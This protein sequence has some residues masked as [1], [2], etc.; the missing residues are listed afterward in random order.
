MASLPKPI[1]W[2]STAASFTGVIY[3]IKDWCQGT[4][5]EG[6]EKLEGKIVIV[7]GANTG[8]GKEVAHDLAR[9]DA[10]VVMACRDMFK[11]E[12]ARTEIVF[13][14]KNKYVYCRKCDLSS[15]QSIREFVELF[16]KEFSKLHILINN[17]GVMRTPK[18]YTKEG[19]EL[20]LGVNHM[21]HFL[22]TNLLLD[23][24]IASAPSRIVNVSSLAHKRGVINTFDLNSEEKYD[25]G[26]AYAQSK[27]ANVMFT[28]E[29]AKKLKGTGVT[30]NA[31]HPGVVS[32]EIA[33]HLKHFNG[34]LGT[35]FMKPI[36]WPFVKTPKNGAQT[37][38]YAALSPELKDVSGYYFSE[39]KYDD[40]NP[41]AHKPQLTEWLWRTSEKWT[42]L[43]ENS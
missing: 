16:K 38:L 43:N 32:T 37:V 26:K 31:V 18:S 28:I 29:L 8:I 15:Q 41:L 21:G 40:M 17:A 1:I 42:H 35:I 36:I 19:I 4:K 7:T 3:L 34:I 20:Q 14:T 6:N 33:R 10:R 23:T 27:L 13:D 9:R 5:Y 2:A 12:N 39:C 11:C 24:L 25:E 22:L 30:A